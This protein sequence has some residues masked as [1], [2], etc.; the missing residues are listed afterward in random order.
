[1]MNSWRTSKSQ[2][3]PSGIWRERKAS[4]APNLSSSDDQLYLDLEAAI[5]PTQEGGLESRRKWHRQ[6]AGE[7]DW[8]LRDS[9]YPTAIP[10]DSSSDH[11]SGEQEIESHC[12]PLCL[13]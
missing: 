13:G 5:R 10:A 8:R 11:F 1:M 4:G 7:K 2:T 9:A 3:M 6:M 12:C